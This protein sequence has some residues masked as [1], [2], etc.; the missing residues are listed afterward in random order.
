MWSKYLA[1]VQKTNQGNMEIRLLLLHHM[2]DLNPVVRYEDV[3]GSGSIAP[4]IL[5]PTLDGGEEWLA[6]H[7]N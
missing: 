7:I 3:L 4:R 1:S 5:T 2:R 6:S